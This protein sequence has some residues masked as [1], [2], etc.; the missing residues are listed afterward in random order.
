MN[1]SIYLSFYNLL[2]IIVSR[3]SYIKIAVNII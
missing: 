2:T 1:M 3:A